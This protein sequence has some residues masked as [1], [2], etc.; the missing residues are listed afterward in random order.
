MTPTP[1]APEQATAI[2]TLIG[3]FTPAIVD[4]F[5]RDTWRP[6]TTVLL[7]LLVSTVLYV[8]AHLAMGTLAYPITLEFITGLLAVFGVQQ[9]TFKLVYENRAGATN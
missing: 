1:I 9:L 3:I 2:A 6:T 5:K 4:F 8:L 7:G